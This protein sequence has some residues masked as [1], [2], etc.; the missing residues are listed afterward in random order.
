MEKFKV[1]D[2]IKW[3][4]YCT[5]VPEEYI[6]LITK[7]LP[8]PIRDAGDSDPSPS[9]YDIEVLCEGD[10]VQWVSWQCELISESR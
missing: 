1:G 5:D 10:Y 8:K 6:G 7:I 2:L 4:N 9:W 3:I